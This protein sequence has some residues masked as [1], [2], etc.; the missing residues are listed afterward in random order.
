MQRS[1]K[2]KRLQHLIL[3]DVMSIT[4]PMASSVFST[5][6]AQ[7]SANTVLATQ[8]QPTLCSTP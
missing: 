1:V 6:F 8:Q 4:L 5:M 7:S 2:V 3:A